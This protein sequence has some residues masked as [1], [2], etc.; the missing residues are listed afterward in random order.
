M[1]AD[2][3]IET[4]NMAVEKNGV[5]KV[6]VRHKPRLLSDNGPCY[7]SQELNKYLGKR[8]ITHTRGCLLY[9]SPSPRDA[10]L[11]RMPSSA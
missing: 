11:S 10:T 6:H 3:V 9:T 7:L 5:T 2:D 8:G 4:L 1:S